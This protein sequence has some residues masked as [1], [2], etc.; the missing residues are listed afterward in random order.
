[1]AGGGFTTNGGGSHFEAKITPMVII[2]CIMA[3]T[4]G[5]M[6]G[7]DVGVSG[8]VTAMPPFLKKFFPAVYRKTVLEKGVDSNYCKYDNEGLQLFTSSLYLAGLTATF[9]ASYT[10]R[11]LGRRLTMLI[12][13]IFFIL[14]VIFNA[15]AQNLAMLIVGRLLL[16]CGV[17]FANQ[18]V[19][20]FLSE[21]APSRIRGALNILF[22]LN[23]TIGIL[24][25]NLVNYG[26][27]KIKGG[28]GWRLSLGLAGIPALLLTV[29]ALLV[30]DTPNSLIE[31][32]RLEEGKAVLRKIR[33]TDN[34]E[35]EF[36]ELVEASRVAKEVKHPF[37]NLLKRRNRPQLVISIA[38]QIFQQ[39]TG[40][41]A[42]M[43]YAPVLFNTLGFKN[44]ASLYSAV[45][46]GAVNVL[47]TIVSIY[48]VDKVGRRKLLLEA[49][50]Q[51]FLSQVVIAIILGLKVK[52]HSDDLSKGYAVFVVVL[53]CT[54]V[55][56]FAWS[57]G[58]LGWLIP[59]ETFP[60]ETR[61]AGQSVTVCVNLLFTFVIAQ[62]FLSML[63][64]FKYGIFLFFSGWVLIMSFFV[65]F[66]VPETKNIP[67]EEMTERVWK[68][69]WLWRR[70]IEDDHHDYV[71]DQKLGNGKNNGFDPASQL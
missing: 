53:V 71:A 43:F 69:H 47:S 22:Q 50:V 65:Y 12:A 2:S 44:D 15:A 33:G 6:F 45:I 62:A 61:S 32:G 24:F 68:Q 30:V 5:L 14:G 26:T 18:A 38:L 46:T 40:I 28:W 11:N 36:L 37:R 54:F 42:I 64:H 13:G 52:D 17:G 67:I 9:F 16:G 35:P 10:T 57:W 51:M 66:L 63:C 31:R 8:G 21:I 23:I 56:S 19:P 59:S 20:V 48:S 7:Y 58:P 34:I 41:N 4:G 1:M 3:A 27:N 29:G 70:Y 49:G 39:F 55:S 60:L 25:A